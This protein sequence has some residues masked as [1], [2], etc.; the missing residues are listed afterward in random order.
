MVNVN[1]R[2]LNREV[3]EMAFVTLANHR[4][5]GLALHE[6]DMQ[7]VYFYDPFG[8]RLQVSENRPHH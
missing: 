5:F 1:L 7:T 2:G 6:P 3:P 8:N 4:G